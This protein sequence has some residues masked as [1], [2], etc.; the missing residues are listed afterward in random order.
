MALDV[1]MVVSFL[2]AITATIEGWSL[3][4]ILNFK[5]F[6]QNAKNRLNNIEKEVFEDG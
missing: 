3:R 6:K 1:N 5:L 4:Q 2:L